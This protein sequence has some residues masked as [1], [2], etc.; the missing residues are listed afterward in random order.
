MVLHMIQVSDVLKAKLTLGMTTQ[1]SRRGGTFNDPCEKCSLTME[2]KMA[3]LQNGR[4]LYVNPRR[5]FTT[6]NNFTDG[7][8]PFFYFCFFTKRERKGLDSIPWT[9]KDA[10]LE[11]ILV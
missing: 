8:C 6:G 5:N 3:I 9:D 2:I 4:P 11:L 10:G 7:F 1:T